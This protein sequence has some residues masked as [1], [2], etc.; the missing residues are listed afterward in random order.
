MCN[1][2]SSGESSLK[3]GREEHIDIVCMLTKVL[4]KQ[5]LLEVVC[6]ISK[7]K[8]FTKSDFLQSLSS[9]L[10]NLFGSSQVPQLKLS[11]S[12]SSLNV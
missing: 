3:M 6:Y 2:G 9:I 4:E 11:I 8:T 5:A 1:T 10:C 12:L 7:T